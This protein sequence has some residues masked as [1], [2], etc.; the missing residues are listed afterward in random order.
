MRKVKAEGNK[1]EGKP[2]DKERKFDKEKD[3][4]FLKKDIKNKNL[5]FKKND[6]QKREPK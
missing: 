5:S 1:A 4:K 2:K 3:K 6:E